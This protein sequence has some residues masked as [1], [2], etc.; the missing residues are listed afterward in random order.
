MPIFQEIQYVDG[1]P[2]DKGALIGHHIAKSEKELRNR[3]NCHH[4]FTQFK[5]ITKLQ[6]LKAQR[7]A[8]KAYTRV[9]NL[10][11]R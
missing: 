5:Q 6:Y 2:H 3:L 7:A 1:G 11:F 10:R 4:G 8:R 9:Y